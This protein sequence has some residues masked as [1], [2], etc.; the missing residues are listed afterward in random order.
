MWEGGLGTTGKGLLRALWWGCSGPLQMVQRSLGIL[1]RLQKRAPDAPLSSTGSH[2]VPRAPWC[3]RT[4]WESG[5]C[6][7]GGGGRPSLAQAFCSLPSSSL[8]YLPQPYWVR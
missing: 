2:R 5:T 6:E 3:S 4:P 7:S 8:R 1:T